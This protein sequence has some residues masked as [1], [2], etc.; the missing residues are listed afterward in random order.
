MDYLTR[1][2]F[3]TGVYEGVIGYD[4]IIK[5]L[6]VHDGALVVEEKGIYSVE[7]FLIARRLMYWQVYLHKTVLSAEQML[8]QALKRAKFLVQ[9]G[10][11]LFVP[12][13]LRFLL[14]KDITEKDFADQP[15]QMLDHF[16]ALDDFDIAYALKNW[17]TADDRLLAYLSSGLVNRR[18][19]RLQFS[20]APIAAEQVHKL[21]QALK[22][23]WGDLTPEELP[24]LLISGSESNSAYSKSKEEIKI[25]YK[26]GAVA[27]LSQSSEYEIQ[28]K[29]IKKYFVCYPKAIPKQ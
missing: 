11:S 29:I 28:A 16:A 21:E 7:K 13:S 4:R 26:S 8:I 5:M 3:F 27:P 15:D 9:D 10:V 14:S 1:D 24:H 25:L 20:N 18:L 19:F 22:N 6:S 17:K 2:S 23:W 12:E